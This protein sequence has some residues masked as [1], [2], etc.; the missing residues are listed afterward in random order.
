MKLTATSLHGQDHCSPH[1]DPKLALMAELWSNCSLGEGLLIYWGDHI[2]VLS[3]LFQTFVSLETFWWWIISSLGLLPGQSV[4]NLPTPKR[5]ITH[6]TF[7]KKFAHKYFNILS[8]CMS[9]G[10]CQVER[11]T[12]FESWTKNYELQ[13]CGASFHLSAAENVAQFYLLLQIF[14]YKYFKP[15]ST[16][17]YK[18]SLT[19]ILSPILPSLPNILCPLLSQI[20][21][22]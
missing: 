9:Y 4:N 6:L 17:S 19:N 22:A 15:N 2:C 11:N 12:T 7:D 3:F 14:S 5:F 13:Q 20:F 8:L 10:Y 18:Y 1:P 16:F 21:W